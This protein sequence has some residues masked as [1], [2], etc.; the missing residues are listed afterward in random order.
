MQITDLEAGAFLSLLN[1]SNTYA[2]DPTASGVAVTGGSGSGMTVDVV[3][4]VSRSY[5]IRGFDNGSFISITRRG[6]Q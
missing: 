1:P 3:G 4:T 6:N 5:F 2:T